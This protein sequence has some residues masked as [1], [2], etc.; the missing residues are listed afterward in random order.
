[1]MEMKR[2]LRVLFKT[3]IVLLLLPLILVYGIFLYVKFVNPGAE[4]T[5]KETTEFLEQKRSAGNGFGG[6]PGLQI[7]DSGYRSERFF[8][9]D[10]DHLI[11]QTN[12]NANFA[13]KSGKIYVWDL[14]TNIIKPLYCD[15]SINGYRGNQLYFLKRS[16]IKG[17]SQGALGANRFASELR[18]FE[19]RWILDDEVNITDA[20]E[21]P[22]VKYGVSWMGESLP[23]F[24]VRREFREEQRAP[25]H[26]IL[27]LAEWGWVLRM[28]RTGPDYWGQSVPEMG[29]IDLGG[30]IYSE[31][32]GT[33]VGDMIDLPAREYP[34]LQVIY[35][36]YLDLY[37][38]ANN[39]YGDLSKTRTM[40]FVD[41]KGIFS[42]YL[43]PENWAQYY[44]I[45]VPTRKGMFWSG[46]DYREKKSGGGEK[47]AFIRDSNGQIHKVI[48][49]AATAIKM[50]P[51]GCQIAFFNTLS[52]EDR[53][54]SS[55]KNF[56]ACNSTLENGVISDV[57]Y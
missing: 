22:S 52:E 23:S 17:S 35:I 15:C 2:A 39:V 50:S 37:W 54:K 43:W 21:P 55:L 41:R 13:E 11:F 29:F 56:N 46:I 7:L 3:V 24:R 33:K 19:D 44:A 26:R 9:M 12:Y 18:E 48:E 31:Q 10:S 38:L 42:A 28:P 27:H 25:D 32:P 5:M 8:W 16:E 4:Q 45:P 14:T 49:G 6:E 1:M 30:E 40:G 57:E 47:G 20:L 36:E 51:D 53:S 34:G